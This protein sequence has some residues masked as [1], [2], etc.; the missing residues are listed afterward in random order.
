[1]EG[2]LGVRLENVLDVGQQEVPE[3]VGSL[4]GQLGGHV[5]DGAD[6][7]TIA[8]EALLVLV[9]VSII[10]VV[11]R[12]MYR[13][14]KLLVHTEYLISRKLIPILVYFLTSTY[15]FEYV[16]LAKNLFVPC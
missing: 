13:L 1:M 10:P 6:E 11:S 5:V 7:H 4:P 3:V 15:I 12:R 2:L 16:C 9:L 14:P 8:L